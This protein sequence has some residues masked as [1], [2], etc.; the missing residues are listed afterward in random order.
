MVSANSKQVLFHSGDWRLG[1]PT[2]SGPCRGNWQFAS[3]CASKFQAIDR[4]KH[5]NSADEV[6]RYLRWVMRNSC[7]TETR[8]IGRGGTGS[9]LR[10]TRIPPIPLIP[11]IPLPGGSGHPRHAQQ[12]LPLQVRALDS[13]W[14]LPNPLIPVQSSHPLSFASR[15][16]FPH[17]LYAPLWPVP[18]FYNC[19]QGTRKKATSRYLSWHGNHGTAG[20]ELWLQPGLNSNNNMQQHCCQHVGQLWAQSCFLGFF[21]YSFM[22]NRPT[23][24]KAYIAIAYILIL[25]L[26]CWSVS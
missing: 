22:R 4:H 10:T 19:K 23:P 9:W 13:A 11:L 17:A 18:T 1:Q 20:I 25:L 8:W 16:Q 24:C 12:A 15:C 26:L 6:L 14:F 21:K 7:H 2:R 5:Q 3:E